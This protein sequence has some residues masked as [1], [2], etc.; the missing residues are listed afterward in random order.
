MSEIQLI[1]QPGCKLVPANDVDYE[2]INKIRN[3]QLCLA[4]IVQ[5]RNPK[6]HRR[7]F[8]L[9]NFGYEYWN[10]EPIEIDGQVIEAEKNFERF[11]KDILIVS[12]F[13]TM[14][15]NIKNEVRYEAESI[16][17]ANMDETRFNE[18]YQLVFNTIWRLVLSKVSGMTE[19][20]VENTMNQLLAFD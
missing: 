4:K 8:A 10:P 3:G 14:V 13:R 11:R 5:P 6:F 17:F 9:L 18:V 19:E 2:I 12:G 15:V 7:F 20:I 1:K 16:S